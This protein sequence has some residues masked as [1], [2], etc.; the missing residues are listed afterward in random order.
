MTPTA[1]SFIPKMICSRSVYVLGALSV[2]G[3]WEGVFTALGD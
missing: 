3:R 1:A 2:A